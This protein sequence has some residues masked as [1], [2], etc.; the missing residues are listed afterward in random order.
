ML[1]DRVRIGIYK[2]LKEDLINPNRYIFR[3]YDNSITIQ[4]NTLKI[5]SVGNELGGYIVPV[6][7]GKSY[8]ITFNYTGSLATNRILP[9]VTYPSNVLSYTEPTVN[10]F[11]SGIVWTCPSG[12]THI[13]VGAYASAIATFSNIV[14]EKIDIMY[15]E[16]Y[17]PAVSTTINNLYLTSSSKN[18][19]WYK[20]NGNA[21]FTSSG[22]LD[23]GNYSQV[24]NDSFE[25]LR[26]DFLT[27]GDI[28]VSY[29]STTI[30]TKYPLTL[31]ISDTPI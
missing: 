7:D 5:V 15:L 24:L 18:K 4:G 22:T 20:V 31:I 30:N 25:K 1:A 21:G 3:N 16:K 19:I 13:V 28:T 10:G 2:S 17:F 12:I 29:Q 23:R 27:N 9:F 26:L 6:E 8:R 11:T 14:V